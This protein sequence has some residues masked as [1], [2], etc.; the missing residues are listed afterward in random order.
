[1]HKRKWVAL[2]AL[3]VVVGLTLMGAQKVYF[4]PESS[5]GIPPL[6]QGNPF[7]PGHIDSRLIYEPLFYYV[8]GPGNTIPS[9][10]F[11]GKDR[12]ILRLAASYKAEPT[13]FTVKLHK[14]ARWEDGTPFT[15]KDVWC[16]YM[17]RYLEHDVIWTVLDRVEISDDY[18]V[19]FH[20]KAPFPYGKAM[21][22]ISSLI[23]YP[24][25]IYGKWA[26]KVDPTV[27]VEEEP[28]KSLVASLKEFKPPRP[29]TTGP[30]IFKTATTS[31]LLLVKNPNYWAADTIENWETWFD[32][33]LCR[34]HM[35]DYNAR[36]NNIMAGEVD[37][38]FITVPKET[39]DSILTVPG[40]RFVAPPTASFFDLDFNYDKYP[41]NILEFRK[42][43]AYA[44]DRRAVQEVAAYYGFPIDKYV[45]GLPKTF[46]EEWLSPEFLA[47]L[48]TY[49]YNPQK[50]EKILRGIG[51]SR[52][53]DGNWRDAAGKQ[54]KLA[55][56]TW[57]PYQ[58]WVL[59]A[60][61]I[62]HQ[63]TKFGFP[64]ELRPMP[65][66]LFYD[67]WD[68]GDFHLRVWY[69]GFW[70][71]LSPWS[72]YQSTFGWDLTRPESLS[73]K[74]RRG[75]NPKDAVWAAFLVDR[76]GRAWKPEEQKLIVEKLAELHNKNVPLIPF[77]QKREYMFQLDGKRVTGWPD[78][79]DPVWD[80][81]TAQGPQ[82]YTTLLVK[83]ILKPVR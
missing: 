18:T 48:E 77:V 63:L 82:C 38:S 4:Q 65:P 53:P 24:Y 55:I 62:S 41:C 13:K 27:P 33:V 26:E 11:A 74:G 28:N 67:A 71:T 31:E 78:P 9:G 68:R 45:T 69:V 49:E 47:K 46:E 59:A 22:A 44:I 40:M 7:A 81:V 15:S 79:D 36:L 64:T 1:M 3:T 50:A 34:P 75:L 37:L 5:W 2:L 61:N 21:I 29:I 20:W 72:G 60:D 70:S 39:V 43:L 42:A 30:F 73:W 6:L 19:I 52:G 83:G 16:T 17:I 35:A 14:D 56:T 8:P 51:W 80:G 12:V 32:G 10:V 66:E 25:H 76:L 54:I 58:D 23:N 57:G